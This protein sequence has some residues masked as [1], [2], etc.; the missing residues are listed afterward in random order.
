MKSIEIK[1][2]RDNRIAVTLLVDDV[3]LANELYLKAKAENIEV[4]MSEDVVKMLNKSNVETDDNFMTSLN[5]KLKI[6]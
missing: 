6:K 3:E 1:K 5:K 4:S 2:A